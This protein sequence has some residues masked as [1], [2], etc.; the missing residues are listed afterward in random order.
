[1]PLRAA[2]KVA[3][4]PVTTASREERAKQ[5]G[6]VLAISDVSDDD[7]HGVLISPMVKGLKEVMGSVAADTDIDEFSQTSGE[8][9]DRAFT[10]S[11]S[12]RGLRIEAVPRLSCW[13]TCCARCSPTANAALAASACA[14]SWS[15]PSIAAD[16]DDLP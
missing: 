12:F 8:S 1:M 5:D 9:P 13:D 2:A 3:P 16:A 10:P 6:D 15:T 7:D 11:N 14:S 4:L